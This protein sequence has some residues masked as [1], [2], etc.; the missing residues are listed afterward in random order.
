M[1]AIKN[2]KMVEAAR[3]EAQQL[4]SEDSTLLKY[5]AIT[6]RLLETKHEVHFE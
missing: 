6:E 2:I 1:E 3:S 4:L 5:P